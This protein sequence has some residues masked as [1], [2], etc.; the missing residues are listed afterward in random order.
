MTMKVFWV[1]LVFDL[2]K[3]PSWLDSFREVYDEPF[4]YHITLKYATYI[5][6]KETERLREKTKRIADETIP[7]VVLFDNYFFDKTTTGNLIMIA[8]QPNE[9]LY[10]LQEKVV[11]RLTVFGKN[12]K[13]YY[14]GF[15]EDFKPHITIARKL[16]EN[17]FLEAKEQIRKPILCQTRITDLSLTIVKQTDDNLLTPDERH[18]Y[19]LKSFPHH[20]K[21]LP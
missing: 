13:P 9:E 18:Q 21:N 7:L 12:I 8:A 19:A 16:T 14:Q 15:E 10:I 11:S 6:N 4:D 1:S 2:Q 5:E 20:G 3:K 17:R